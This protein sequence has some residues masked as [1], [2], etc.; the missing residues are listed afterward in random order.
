[1]G[2]A[3][4]FYTTYSTIQESAKSSQQHH[5][6]SGPSRFTVTVTDGTRKRSLELNS[7]RLWLVPWIG[8]WTQL[9]VPGP[10]STFVGCIG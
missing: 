6:C 8:L 9:P 4:S 5:L 2:G 1:V 7:R 3:R 10:R